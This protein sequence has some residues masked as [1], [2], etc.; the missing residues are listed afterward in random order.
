MLLRPNVFAG[1]PVIVVKT[2]GFI[3]AAQ[4]LRHEVG[5][6]GEHNAGVIQLRHIAFQPLQG[7]I[8]LVIDG[9]QSPH[10][11]VYWQISLAHH[12]VGYPAVFHDGIL[13]V[14]VFNIRSQVLHRL[15][16][17]FVSVAVGMMHIPQSADAVAF[18]LV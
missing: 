10:D 18:N 9:A 8:A 17:R 12:F 7:N 5:E 2:A 15:L 13:D 16:G 6:L 11:G 3:G 14:G 4:I 1:F